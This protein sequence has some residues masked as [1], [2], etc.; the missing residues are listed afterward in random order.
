M[1]QSILEDIK[2]LLNITPEYT[3]FDQDIKI[4]INSALATLNQIGVGPEAGFEVVDST[5]EWSEFISGTPLN[6]V[7]SYVYARVRLLFD[8]PATSFGISAIENQIKELEWR[9][10]VVA[11][12][13]EPTEI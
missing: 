4:H 9:L 1:A 12:P 2:K 7:K 10:Q 5:A 11:T 6:S 13:I 8:P 3:V